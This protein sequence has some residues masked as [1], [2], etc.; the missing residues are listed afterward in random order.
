MYLFE[1]SETVLVHGV[2]Y[3]QSGYFWEYTHTEENY[4]DKVKVD[5]YSNLITDRNT[6]SSTPRKPQQ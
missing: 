2:E 6:P 4:T 1:L 3:E 5:I